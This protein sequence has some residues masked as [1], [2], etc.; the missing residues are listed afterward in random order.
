MHQ[1]NEKHRK[2]AQIPHAADILVSPPNDNSNC[3]AS[4]ARALTNA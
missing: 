1:K 4:Q 3:Y 2:P